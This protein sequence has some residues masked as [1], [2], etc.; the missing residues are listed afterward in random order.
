MSNNE[1]LTLELRVYVCC[2]L[3]AIKDLL[4]TFN[5]VI[6]RKVEYMSSMDCD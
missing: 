5:I 2:M 6:I 1:D 4:L 3:V